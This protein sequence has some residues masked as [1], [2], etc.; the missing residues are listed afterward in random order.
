[1]QEAW[2]RPGF[3][4][5]RAVTGPDEDSLT[6]GMQAALQVIADID[7]ST[8][9]GLIFASTTGVSAE[10]PCAAMLGNALGLTTMRAVSI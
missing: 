5:S 9:V 6:L 2:N 10:K 8:I 3:P 1:V 4:G 7:K